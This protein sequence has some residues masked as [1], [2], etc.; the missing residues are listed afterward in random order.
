M[1]QRNGNELDFVEKAVCRKSAGVLELCGQDGCDPVTTPYAWL[2]SHI[3]EKLRRR[4]T[5]TVSESKWQIEELFLE[6]CGDLITQDGEN[7]DADILSLYW[8]GYALMWMM[9]S[10]DMTGPELAEKY[11]VMWWIANWETLHTLPTEVVCERA[12]EDA[13]KGPEGGGE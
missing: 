11:D 4:D 7:D 9:I 10:H 5:D 2:G 8:L 1:G 6:Q 3:C 12:E 13:V